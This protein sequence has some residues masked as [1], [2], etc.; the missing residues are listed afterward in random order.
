M[1]HHHHHNRYEQEQID[2]DQALAARMQ[3]EEQRGYSQG[4][5]SGGYQGG[6]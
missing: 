3:A 4:G 5:P 6:G 2:S 1:S